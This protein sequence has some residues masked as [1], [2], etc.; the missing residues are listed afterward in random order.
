MKH[1]QMLIIGFVI[2]IVIGFTCFQLGGR[3]KTN[4]F[5]PTSLNSTMSESIR[6][7]RSKRIQF[8][9][10]NMNLNMNESISDK[11]KKRI[12][13]QCES[14]PLQLILLRYVKTKSSLDYNEIAKSIHK[15]LVEELS[16]LNIMETSIN[17]EFIVIEEGL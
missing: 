10:K 8:I 14:T 9:I 5:A 13:K 12:I 17:V 7:T 3:Y 11:L 2:Y 4:H 16:N 1:R 15:S 6:I